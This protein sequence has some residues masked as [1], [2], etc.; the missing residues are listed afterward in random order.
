MRVSVR[1]MQAVDVRAQLLKSILSICLYMF[2]Y[3]LRLNSVYMHM[4]QML[5]PLGSFFNLCG[6]YFFVHLFLPGKV[7]YSLDWPWIHYAAKDAP[8]S[9][10]Q[11]LS[12]QAHMTTSG[13]VLSLLSFF[14]P[15]CI[16][17]DPTLWKIHGFVFYE[18]WMISDKKMS[19][20]FIYQADVI[21]Q[22]LESPRK[23]DC[24]RMHAFREEMGSIP[25]SELSLGHVYTKLETISLGHAPDAFITRSESV[26]V[27]NGEN[28]CRVL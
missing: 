4:E 27:C 18:L 8:V 9:T 7:S 2:L 6:C 24:A 1:A 25:S 17:W 21:T 16:S 15:Q 3:F 5:Y 13:L 10:Y 20:C 11:V 22:E 19:S 28:I 14:Q 12:S 26:D 23:G